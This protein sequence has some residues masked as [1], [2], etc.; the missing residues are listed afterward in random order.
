MYNGKKKFIKFFVFNL[1]KQRSYDK[2]QESF[3]Y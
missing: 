1:K 3:K 2:D